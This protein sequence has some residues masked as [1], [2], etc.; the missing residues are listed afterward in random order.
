MK[1][2]RSKDNITYLKDIKLKHARDNNRLSNAEK[3]QGAPLTKDQW[4]T[5]TSLSFG[6]FGFLIAGICLQ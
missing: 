4:E 5:A 1:I 6:W 3:E 2:I